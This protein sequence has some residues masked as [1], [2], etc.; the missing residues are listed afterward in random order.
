[1][2][3]FNYACPF[4]GQN[5]ECD[6]SMEYGTFQCP[7]CKNDIVPE[8]DS[9]GSKVN[10][11]KQNHAEKARFQKKKEEWDRAFF[12]E[13]NKNFTPPI[14]TKIFRSL[15]WCDLISG[16]IALILFVML[17]IALGWEENSIPFIVGILTLF[18]SA[19]L[20]FGIAQLTEYIGRI[21]SNSDKMLEIAKHN[22]I[23]K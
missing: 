3:N 23:K 20:C 11:E 22:L 9:S 8:R 17:L 19:V 4:C 10:T 13:I 6:D 5:L 15:G 14:L 2:G 7:E 1:M 12:E 21:C 18:F 16:L